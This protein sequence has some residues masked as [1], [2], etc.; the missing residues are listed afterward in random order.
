M[1]FYG[2]PQMAEQKQDDQLEHTYS[3]YVRIRDV[4]L[5][6]CR[7]RWTIGRSGERGS[8]KSVQA[9]RHDND[10]D[11]IFYCCFSDCSLLFLSI[12]L[13]GYNIWSF[14]S[15]FCIFSQTLNPVIN[16]IF[17]ACMSSSSFFSWHMKSVCHLLS[18]RSCPTL[19]KL[20]ATAIRTCHLQSLI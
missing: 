3:S 14:F 9:A 13:T 8:R 4:A 10:D 6:T 20:S 7:R 11:D 15:L 5:K 12:L 16:A 2:P 17:N 19:I 18:V 1:Y